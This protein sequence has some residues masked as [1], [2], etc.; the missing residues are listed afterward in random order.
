[1]DDKRVVALAMDIDAYA[2]FCQVFL[3][4]PGDLILEKGILPVWPARQQ[5]SGD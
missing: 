3:E 1:V 5:S 4:D 2:I